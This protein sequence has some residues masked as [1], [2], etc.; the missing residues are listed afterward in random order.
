MIRLDGVSKRYP[1][2]TV[3]VHELTLDVQRGE[4]VVLVGPSG[5]GK[6]TT[7]KMVN[8]LVEPSGGRIFVDGTD[9]THAD[10]VRLRRGIGYVIQNVGLFPHRSIAENVA[11][12]PELSGW[13]KARRRERARELLALVG[14]DPD[15]Y[16]RRYPHELSGGQRQ[17][18]GV[19]RALAADPPVL[20]MDEPFSAVDPVVRSQLQDEF[21]RLQ[22][23]VRKTILFVTHDIEEAVRLGDRIA[24]FAQGGRLEQFDTPAAVLGSPATPFVSD[25]VGFDRG[26]KRLSVTPVTRADLEYPPLVKVSD[27]LRSAATAMN[28]SRWAVVQ[29]ESGGLAGWIGREMCDADGVVGDQAR[30]MEAWVALDDSLKVAFAEMLQWNA[31]WIA[32]LDH[33]DRY[34]GVLTPSTLH[35]ALRRSVE[36]ESRSIPPSEVD[37]VTV[38]D[39]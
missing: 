39:A 7:M 38:S 15:T 33:D 32:V 25:F 26:L 9:V 6:T 11:V 28:T 34:L 5:C 24:V 10:H 4:L 37:L 35:A 8:R 14:L 1:D 30:R 16:A 36:A 12:V 3:A 2:G 18:V 20:L 27:S 29:D 22:E 17:R 23:D 31:G 19:A 13:P 21:L